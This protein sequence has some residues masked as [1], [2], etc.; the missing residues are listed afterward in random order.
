[1][2]GKEGFKHYTV[3]HSQNF[4]NPDT[5]KH[6]QL[7][8]CLWSVAKTKIMKSM[9][10]TSFKN[11]PLHLAEFWYRSIQP[12]NGADFFKALVNDMKDYYGKKFF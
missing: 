11:L 7:I 9:K 5:K 3:N 1:M 2:I 10:G 8:E 12:Q 6:S 4:V